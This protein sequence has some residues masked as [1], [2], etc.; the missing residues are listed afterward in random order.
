MPPNSKE[1]LAPPKIPKKG[2]NTQEEKQNHATTSHHATR[3]TNQEESLDLGL[4]RGQSRPVDNSQKSRKISPSHPCQKVPSP[5]FRTVSV[6]HYLATKLLSK[7]L[8]SWTMKET[9][10]PVI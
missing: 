8:E 3:K 10:V 5:R 4:R 7:E 9:M 1:G 6:C 2:I